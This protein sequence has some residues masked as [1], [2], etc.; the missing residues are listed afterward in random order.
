MASWGL[1]VEGGVECHRVVES[2]YPSDEIDPTENRVLAVLGGVSGI[3]GI[4]VARPSDWNILGSVENRPE[5]C[6]DLL[7]L[8]RIDLTVVAGRQS[9]L[10]ISPIYPPVL[11]KTNPVSTRQRRTPLKNDP[12]IRQRA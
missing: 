11:P 9:D 4:I 2:G 12:A 10:R 5:K 3:T 6:S 1:G 7:P 8:G